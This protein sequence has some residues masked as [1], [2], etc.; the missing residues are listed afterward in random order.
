M[1]AALEGDAVVRQAL[2]AAEHCVTSRLTLIECA[3]A[4]RRAEVSGRLARKDRYLTQAWVDDFLA[5]AYVMAVDAAVTTRASQEFALE[6]VRSLDAI[7]LASVCVWDAALPRLQVASCD[8]QLRDN[9]DAMGY[10]LVPA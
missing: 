4:L 10:A 8:V 2:E 6:P 1:R 9:L 5:G 3:R 7:H